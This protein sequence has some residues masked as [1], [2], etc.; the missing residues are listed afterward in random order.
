[1]IPVANCKITTPDIIVRGGSIKL[2]VIDSNLANA[3]LPIPAGYTLIASTFTKMFDGIGQEH[4]HVPNNPQVVYVRN[5]QETFDTS[6][7]T[8][9]YVSY[10]AVYQKTT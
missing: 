9:Y 4:F 5:T 8:S 7:A 10:V 2:N 6:G 3:Q 1:M